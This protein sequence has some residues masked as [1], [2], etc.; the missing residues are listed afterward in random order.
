MPHAGTGEKEVLVKSAGKSRNGN[1]HEPHGT[2]AE[3]LTTMIRRQEAVKEAM[4]ALRAEKKRQRQMNRETAAKLHSLIG[5]AVA[6]DLETKTEETPTRKAYIAEI[7]SRHFEKQSGARALLE[8]N[9][10]L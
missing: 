10:W 6:A 8:A 5:A 4:A 2:A 3:K 1:G 9:G 7:L